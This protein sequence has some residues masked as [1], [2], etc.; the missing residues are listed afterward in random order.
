MW[1]LLLS[2]N[3]FINPDTFRRITMFFVSFVFQAREKYS[4]AL[5]WKVWSVRETNERE[6]WIWTPVHLAE[7]WALIHSWRTWGPLEIDRFYMCNIL[8]ACFCVLSSREN[9]C[10]NVVWWKTL[11]RD[12][13]VLLSQKKCVHS[14]TESAVVIYCFQTKGCRVSR[15]RLYFRYFTTSIYTLITI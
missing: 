14:W 6:K 11:L 2:D 10:L 12:A 9:L 13:A 15:N 5:R 4:A 7:T 1:T 3:E 8:W